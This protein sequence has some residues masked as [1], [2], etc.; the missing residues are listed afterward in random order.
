MIRSDGLHCVKCGK[1]LDVTQGEWMAT[2][3]DRMD[4]FQ[5][6]HAPQV[7]FPFLVN[8]PMLWS[9]LV[10]NKMRQPRNSFMQETLG[11]ACDVGSRIL[12]QK[13]IDAHTILPDVMTLQG[14]LKRYVKR[15]G[16][17]DWGGAEEK[18]FTVHVIIGI[19]A[20]GRLDVIYGKRYHGFDPDEVLPSIAKAHKFYECE[21]C[22]ADYGM[23]FDKNVLLQK[24][25]GIRM[26]QMMFCRQNKLL[27]YAPTLGYPRWTVDKTTALDTLFMAIKNDR[28]F[29]PREGFELLL[30]DL[31]SPFEHVTDVGGF[32]TRK[33]L[34]NPNQPDD[35]CMALCFGSMLAMKLITGGDGIDMIPASAF[36]RGI[37]DTSTPVDTSVLDPAD[38]LSNV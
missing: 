16:G 38:V 34:R 37:V 20:D 1:K 22:A 28:I 19:R 9:R 24:T 8:N 27:S 33:Y 15:V 3:D 11:I 17:I 32:T 5:G 6:Y 23:G 2:Y 10:A 25:F 36:N 13:D 18:S 29:F 21:M 30:P 14:N 4:E 35:F 31:M 26:C 7:I 12:T